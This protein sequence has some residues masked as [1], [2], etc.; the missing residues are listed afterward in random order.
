MKTDI[1]QRTVNFPLKVFRS[2]KRRIKGQPGDFLRQVSGVIHVGANAG[3]EK[4]TYARHNLDVIWIE[5]IP[6]VFAQLKAGL[7]NFPRQRALRALV[8]DKDN[9]EYTFHI[10]SND[11]Q[12]SSIFELELHKDIWSEVYFEKSIQLKSVSLTTLTERENIDVSKYD[13]LIMDTQGS[14]LLVLS[15]AERL[16]DGFKYIKTEVA[17]FEIYKGCCQLKDIE[18]FLAK[19]GF[20]E[21]S[22]SEFAARTAGGACY[23]IIYQNSSRR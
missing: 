20:K 17:D 18:N 4:E 9:E 2:V 13:A 5:P 22:R 23:D 19:H 8:T 16:L 15:G 21:F 11:G 14:E 10:A 12:S 1:L 7:E 3:Q 6:E